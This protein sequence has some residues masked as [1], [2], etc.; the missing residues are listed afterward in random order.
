MGVKLSDLF[1][2][3]ADYDVQLADYTSAAEDAGAALSSS[4]MRGVVTG[5]NDNKGRITNAINEAAGPIMVG[6]QEG[7]AASTSNVANTFVT[8]LG[9]AFSQWK[10]ETFGMASQPQTW[11]HNEG[12]FFGGWGDILKGSMD[13][14]NSIGGEPQSPAMA[15]RMFFGQLP[16]ELRNISQDILSAALGMVLPGFLAGPAADMIGTMLGTKPILTPGQ[17]MA[18][19][20][21]ADQGGFGDSPYAGGS[22]IINNQ[23]ALGQGNMTDTEYEVSRG[24][25]QS[26]RRLGVF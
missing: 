8:S 18:P 25:L 20:V 16:T 14:E 5:V 4:F 24:I 12:G 13:W 10:N 22:Y 19:G 11:I 1:I 15:S 3:F 23:F 9:F 7:I 6:V 17:A 26:M 21:S 2:G